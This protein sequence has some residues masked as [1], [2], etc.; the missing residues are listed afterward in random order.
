LF[1]IEVYQIAIMHSLLDIPQEL[2][3]KI[4]DLV[5]NTSD[6]PAPENPHAAGDYV[7]LK[8]FQYKSWTSG[9]HVLYP[10]KPVRLTTLSLLLVNCALYHQTRAALKR[11]PQ[12]FELD[13][14]LVE[15][16]QLWA[17]W[18]QIPSYRAKVDRVHVSFRLFPVTKPGPGGYTGFKMATGAPP[19]IYWQLHSLLERSLIRGPVSR[20]S[21]VD[22]PPNWKGFSCI[23]VLE[24]DVIS[25]TG[26]EIATDEERQRLYFERNDVVK[27]RY[28][29][30]TLPPV[31]WLH[32]IESGIGVLTSLYRDAVPMG[33]ILFERVGKIKS[34]L[35]GEVQEELDLGVILSKM[36]YR[37]DT[38][39]THPKS[40][41][42]W[43]RMMEDIRSKR[44]EAGLITFPFEKRTNAL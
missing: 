18:V 35:D 37:R 33:R 24:L 28:P 22:G 29:C 5:I 12:R 11:N 43:W 21:V 30:P 17:T 44:E 34:M 38:D 26:V 10:K 36:E 16:H 25:P 20:S 40:A 39:D 1:G 23:E 31:R 13:V 9:T 7:E 14:M 41:T 3:D 32:T 19:A 8:D 42:R 2:R 15:E 4:L 6:N 27:D